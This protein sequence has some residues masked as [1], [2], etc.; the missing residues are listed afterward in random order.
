MSGWNDGMLDAK[1]SIMTFGSKHIGMRHDLACFSFYHLVLVC[2][3]W[4]RD[5][6]SG[7]FFIAD[8]MN[9]LFYCSGLRYSVLLQFL[10][11]N[12]FWN[13]NAYLCFLSMWPVL[14][15]RQKSVIAGSRYML[16]AL[17]SPVYL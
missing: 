12:R 10:E 6:L 1:F 5:S 2:P 16:D 11:R 14:I 8:I 15:Y 9:I 3:L 13:V 17:G 7:T 4:F